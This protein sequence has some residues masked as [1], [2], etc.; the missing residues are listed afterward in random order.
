MQ[1]D[2]HPRRMQ[3]LDLLKKIKHTAIIDRVR[4]IQTHNM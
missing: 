1:M 3:R 4:H 2:H